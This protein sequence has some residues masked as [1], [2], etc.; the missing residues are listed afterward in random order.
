MSKFFIYKN[1]D[2]SIEAYEVPKGYTDEEVKAHLV[3]N[4]AQLMREYPVIGESSYDA[5]TRAA[6]ASKLRGD[7]E[8]IRAD[9]A[10]PEAIESYT[11]KQEQAM[12]EAESA[13]QK[14]KRMQQ[15]QKYAVS[16]GGKEG[17]D[18]LLG[19]MG[20]SVPQLV[21][22]GAGL[23]KDVANKYDFTA[24]FP[25]VK[26]TD[27]NINLGE[28][29]ADRYI[30]PYEGDMSE[31]VLG[32]PTLFPSMLIPG[33]GEAKVANTLQKVG[34]YFPK[35]EKA[36]QASV[37]PVKS[38]A[39]NLVQ[40]S[41]ASMAPNEQDIGEGTAIGTGVEGAIKGVGKGVKAVGRKVIQSTV[42]P[43][44]GSKFDVDDLMGAKNVDG[45]NVV[46]PFSGVD[47]IV[48][49]VY[50]ALGDWSKKQS[51]SI[52]D[53]K[54]DMLGKI[55]DLKEEYYQK[56]FKKEIT[57]ADYEKVISVL[58]EEA[59][60]FSFGEKTQVDDYGNLIQE[61]PFQGVHNAKIDVGKKGRYDLSNPDKSEP[62]QREAYRESYNRYSD[63]LGG[64]DGNSE[65][66][67][68]TSAMVPMMGAKADLEKAQERINRN[69]VIPLTSAVLGAGGAATLDPKIA[70]AMATFP[71]L[72]QGMRTGTGAYRAGEAIPSLSRYAVP[73]SIRANNEE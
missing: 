62:I 24:E 65:Y 6:E 57:P 52:P 35:A 26:E 14:N 31:A 56:A 72:F 15:A 2:G 45:S 70:L 7:A 8:R 47:A 11:G 60:R 40:S 5:L 13:K 39:D 38:V 19:Q 30:L 18:A 29:F 12:Q 64:L 50:N 73:A 1:I 20:R 32:D 71:W 66:K 23:V 46:K 42:K 48:E 28:N 69:N 67:Q 63:V 21:K 49:N 54:I 59:K 34:K 9:V 33:V 16:E 58:D 36:V 22:A 61:V 27:P 53:G 10:T 51:E 44:G 3:N 43:K 4:G 17:A 41:V 25:F 68:A 55:N 37:K